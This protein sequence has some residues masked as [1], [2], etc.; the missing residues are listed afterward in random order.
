MLIEVEPS[1]TSATGGQI[2][3]LGNG[4]PVIA[5]FLSSAGTTLH[6][7]ATTYEGFAI[8]P[9]GY[10]EQLAAYTITQA[11]TFFPAVAALAETGPVPVPADAGVLALS[12]VAS[13]SATVGTIL[14]ADG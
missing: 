2:G 4:T 6:Q 7:G 13:S 3:A 5:G 12:V 11:S 9:S 1:Y 8:Y 14:V 10:A